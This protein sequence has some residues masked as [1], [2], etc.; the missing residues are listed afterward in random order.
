MAQGSALSGH[1]DTSPG[2]R[3]ARRPVA[4]WIMFNAVG[5][6]GVLVQLAVLLTLTHVL[7]L[8]YLVAT[9]IAVEIAVIHNF[10]WHRVWTWSDRREELRGRTLVAL[11]RFH[12]S[13][14]AISIVGNLILMR[15][16]HG[17]MKLPIAVANLVSIGVSA[18]LNY[19]AS[20]RFVFR[21]ADV[22]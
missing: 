5:A 8:H 16:L 20:D 17:G 4:R 15:V 21:E 9:A 1:H 19:L 2:R 11:A 3:P 6:L 22:R 10:G 18:F 7:G 14:G 13:N 12:L